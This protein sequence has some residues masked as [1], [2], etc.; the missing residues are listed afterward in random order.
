MELVAPQLTDVCLDPDLGSEGESLWATELSSVGLCS[1][2]GAE[3]QTATVSHVEPSISNDRIGMERC[4][5]GCHS[6][7]SNQ[8][9]RNVGGTLN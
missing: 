7:I 5:E 2:N 6:V 8:S 3:H 9:D 1:L 4:D